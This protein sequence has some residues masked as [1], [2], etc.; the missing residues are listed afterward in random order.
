MLG[1][2]EGGSTALNLLHIPSTLA[3]SSFRTS[4]EVAARFS[5]IQRPDGHA[6]SRRSLHARVMDN[7]KRVCSS[8]RTIRSLLVENNG[9]VLDGPQPDNI[10]HP[11][12]ITDISVKDNGPDIWRCRALSVSI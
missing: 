1:V 3:E 8:D 6:Q 5:A 10:G 9:L 11:P 4:S 2:S 7:A 12:K